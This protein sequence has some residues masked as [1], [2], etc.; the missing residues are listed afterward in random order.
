MPLNRLA[1]RLGSRSGC[2]SARGPRGAGLPAAFALAACCF[3]AA[4]RLAWAALAA[5]SSK[6]CAL[7]FQVSIC[8]CR[9]GTARCTG[10]LVQAAMSVPPQE[11]SIR[12]TG[13]PRRR[14]SS[15]P[16][17][18]A[19]AE[20]SG[21]LAGVATTH[22]PS[23]SAS[24]VC[25]VR[26]GTVNKRICGW[27]A[28]AMALSASR[29]PFRAKAMFDWPEASQTSP[30]R[31]SC[32]TSWFLPSTVSVSAS[33]CAFIGGKFVFQRPSAPVRATTL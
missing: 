9:T 2:S 15:L 33:A 7:W 26:P 31:T 29:L 25:A 27:S 5:A 13:A 4:T 18:Q 8:A 24:G 14:C 1:G 19:T 32:T 6:V 16:K 11:A 30:T 17:N 20:K 28:A 21:A 10:S 23:P 3:Q 22:L 12:P